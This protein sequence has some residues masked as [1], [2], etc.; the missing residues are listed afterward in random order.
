MKNQEKTPFKLYLSGFAIC[1]SEIPLSE[2]QK[3]DPLGFYKDMSEI[4]FRP[5]GSLL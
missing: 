1:K 5:E 3:S 2:C 4:I